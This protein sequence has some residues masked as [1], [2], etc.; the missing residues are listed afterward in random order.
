MQ[1]QLSNGSVTSDDRAVWRGTDPYEVEKPIRKLIRERIPKSGRVVEDLDLLIRHYSTS[2]S[3]GVFR[4][5]ETKHGDIGLTIGQDKSFRQMHNLWRRGDPDATE[6]KGFYLVQ[7]DDAEYGDDS[8]V[9]VTRLFEN[10]KSI[11]MSLSEFVDW[12]DV[13]HDKV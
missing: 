2:N 11:V 10:P 13:Y 9:T 6:Y 1:Q 4:A 7:C 5:I 12:L 8:Q 3:V